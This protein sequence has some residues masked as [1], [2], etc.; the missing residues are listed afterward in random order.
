MSGE[1][2]ILTFSE[3]V[4][5]SA[6]A[7]SFLTASQFETYAN[8]A[9][10]VSAKGASAAAGDAFYDS[11]EGVLKVYDT[12]W[13]AYTGRTL[14]RD[15]T[16]YTDA[17]S[18][19][20]LGANQN[21]HFLVFD[22]SGGAITVNLPEISGS[23][24][25]YSIAC[26]C[27]TAGNDI[28]FNRGGASDTIG[29]SASTTKVLNVAGVGFQLNADDSTSPDQWDSLEFGTVTDGSI[30]RAKLADEAVANVA[31][32]AK[33][34]TYTA[35][36]S[37]DVI[38]AATASGWTLTLPAL[39]GITGKRFILKK[40]SSDSNVW[41]IDGNGSET[42][43]GS[44]TTTIDTENETLEIV[45]GASDWHVIRRH[46][47]SEWADYTPTTQGIGTP[48]ITMA[49]WRRVGDSMEVQAV[50]TCGTTSANELQFGLPNS[51]TLSYPAVAIVGSVQQAAA[52]NETH[53]SVIATNGDSFV[54]V[55]NR[56][57]GTNQILTPRNGNGLFS[58][59]DVITFNFT[60]KITGWKS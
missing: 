60:V 36:T 46:I 31:V 52:N 24:L 4:T 11:T 35:T 27:E 51:K 21:G 15:T 18:P 57:S 49:R 38:T 30:T 43:D 55:G 53:F 10:Y 29:I 44:T 25:P 58:T 22:S 32:V 7:Q 47:P 34:T 39:S 16:R 28:T 3:G 12:T 42:I 9:A 26:L 8:E 45:A 41:T 19:I 40:T 13:V 50:V 20:T 17:D 37:D 48:T 59:S 33:T 5:V 2:K 14:F 1:T 6:P 23:T 56:N 54:N